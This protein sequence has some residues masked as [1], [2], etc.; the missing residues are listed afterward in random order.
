MCSKSSSVPMCAVTVWSLTFEQLQ[1]IETVQHALLRRMVN[2]RNENI[3]FVLITRVDPMNHAPQRYWQIWNSNDP[4]LIF[5]PK[6]Q[7]YWRSRRLGGNSL[8]YREVH[9]K[10]LRKTRVLLPRT[11]EKRAPCRWSER[12]IKLDHC[13]STNYTNNV[14]IVH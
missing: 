2:V 5:S 14:F 9:R 8:L 11:A 10:A 4:S 6:K 13:N 12:L 7:R 1:L 3:S